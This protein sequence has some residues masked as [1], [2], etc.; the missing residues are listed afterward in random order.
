MTDLWNSIEPN[1]HM[2]MA[3]MS[4]GGY[5]SKLRV[6][7]ASGQPP[8]VCFSGLE[9]L[10]SLQYSGKAT[11]LAVP[12]PE[13]YFPDSRLADLGDTARKSITPH[14]RPTVF[15]IWP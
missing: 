9:T 11:N 5:E 7:I 12:I 14:G 13:K 10:E 8:D 2:K 15:P 4:H 1:V 6:A 3:V